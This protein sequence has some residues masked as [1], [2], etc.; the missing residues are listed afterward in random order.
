MNTYSWYK[1]GAVWSFIIM[2]LV[3]GIQAVSNSINPALLAVIM[4]VLG[5]AG[6]YFHVSLANSLGARN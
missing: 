2:F 6:S 5:L 4:A 1:S 3:G